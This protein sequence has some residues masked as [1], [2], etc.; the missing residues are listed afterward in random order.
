MNS[1]VKSKKEKYADQDILKF[2]NNCD[3]CEQF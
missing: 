2:K 3:E 1:K